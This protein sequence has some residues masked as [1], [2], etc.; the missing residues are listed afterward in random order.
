MINTFFNILHGIEQKD[1]P[2]AVALE[3]TIFLGYDGQLEQDSDME[4]ELFEST[5]T[6]AWF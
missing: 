1:V 2:L 4:I 5:I 6:Q 3:M